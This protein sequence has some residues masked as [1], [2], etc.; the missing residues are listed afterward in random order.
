M[1]ERNFELDRV[2]KIPEETDVMELI[3]T[4][5]DL[6][7]DLPLEERSRLLISGDECTLIQALTAGDNNWSLNALPHNILINV[8]SGKISLLFNKR[9]Y[10]VENISTVQLIE[11][12]TP[13]AI[14]VSEKANQKPVIRIQSKLSQMIDNL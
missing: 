1:V 2:T 13:F 4:L 8:L 6:P 10:G 14:H 3:T 12:G 5:Q 11:A 7:N 9:R